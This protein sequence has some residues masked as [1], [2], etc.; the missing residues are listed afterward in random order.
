MCKNIYRLKFKLHYEKNIY[1][2]IYSFKNDLT[3]HDDNDIYKE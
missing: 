3:S 1:L 2:V